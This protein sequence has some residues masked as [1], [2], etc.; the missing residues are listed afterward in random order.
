[1][2][3]P[4]PIEDVILDIEIDFDG[5]GY[6][7]CWQAREGDR[8]GDFETLSQAEQTAFEDFGIIKSQWSEGPA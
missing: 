5:T 4:T 3:L 6:L 8:C 1:M 7:L 2:P